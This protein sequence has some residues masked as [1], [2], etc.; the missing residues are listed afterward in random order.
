[1]PKKENSELELMCGLFRNEAKSGSV[2]Y[3]GK[4]PNTGEE[5]VMFKN[6]YYEEGD[7]KPYF[8]LMKRISA[9]ED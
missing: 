1:M 8:R 9:K 2:Y 3:N 7:N 6:T 5:F 4:H